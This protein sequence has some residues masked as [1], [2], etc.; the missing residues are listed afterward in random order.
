[1]LLLLFL[2]ALLSLERV[3]YELVF[4]PIIKRRR[5]DGDLCK[6]IVNLLVFNE[7]VVLTFY[8]V[9]CSLLVRSRHSVPAW[10]KPGLMV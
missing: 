5:E 4:I 1:L 7:E 3:N 8:C 6:S 10:A 9:T 2:F